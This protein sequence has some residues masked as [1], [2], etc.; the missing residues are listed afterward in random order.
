LFI[1]N[2]SGS[3][4]SHEGVIPFFDEAIELCRRAG[5]TRIL[6]RGD[7]DFSLTEALDRW[8][9]NGVFFVF[10]YDAYANMVAKAQTPLA[11]A[12]LVRHAKRV[13]KTEPRLKQPRVKEEVVRGREFKN[14]KLSSEDV[15]EFEYQPK[16]CT[17]SFRVVVVRKNLSS[18][19]TTHSSTTC[20]TSFTSRMSASSRRLKSFVK[21]TTAGIK[22]T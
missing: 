11:Y 4:P 12:E 17:R 21:R 9:D 15:A 16:K 10:G 2:R 19:T 20:A 5:F 7:T 13:L 22:R 8:D 14:I 1:V 3:R 6:L 18:K